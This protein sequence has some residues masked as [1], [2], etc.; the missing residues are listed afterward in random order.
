MQN[1][2]LAK[3]ITRTRIAFEETAN[4]AVALLSDRKRRVPT[5]A[6]TACALGAAVAFAVAPGSAPD[7]LAGEK[8]IVALPLPQAVSIDNQAE[9][10]FIHREEKVRKGDTLGSLFARLGIDDAE[11]EKNLRRAKDSRSI[12]NNLRPGRTFTSVTAPDGDLKRLSYAVSPTEVIVAEAQGS[13]FNI[14]KQTLELEKRVQL[15]AGVIRS[16]LFGAT[17]VAGIP[18]AIAIQIAEIFGGDIDFHK[19]LRKN[20]AFRVVYETLHHKGEFVSAGKV[21]AVEF[22]NKNKTLSAIWYE[23][24]DAREGANEE[25][26]AGRG[27]YTPEGD[28]LKK[29]FLKAP[30]EFSRITSGFGSRMHPI[31]RLWSAH[32]GVDYAAPTGTPI[33]TVGDG[34]IDFIGVQGGYGNVVIVKHREKFSTLYAHMSAFAGF[35]KGDRVGQGEVIGYVGSTGWSTGP[36]LHYEFR[37]EGEAVDPMNVALPTTVPLE[38]KDREAYLKATAHLN[39]RL[40]LI[41]QSA[42]LQAASNAPVFE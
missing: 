40:A 18:D 8:S 16:S 24:S 34:V 39:V 38:G 27:Y 10:G 11:A 9:L 42:A 20:D 2:I 31:S 17:D 12:L 22:T 21:L 26:G 23:G 19:D 3:G 41:R 36:H 7:P 32:K 5:I 37:V 4:A 1:K 25:P 35:K 30:L 15:K 29:A 33:R 28:S 13:D 6:A 14:T